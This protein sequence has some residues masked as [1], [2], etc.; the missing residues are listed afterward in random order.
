MASSFYDTRWSGAL[1]C[2]I[3]GQSGCGKTSFMKQFLKH[4]K[5]LVNPPFTRKIWCYSE[6]QVAYQSD[7]DDVEFIKGINPDIVSRENLGENQHVALVIDD[8]SDE[9]DEQFLASLFSKISHHR[10][11]SIFF[12]VHSLFLASMKRHRFISQ[13]THVLVIFKSPRDY[14]SVTTL[15]RQMFGSKSYKFAVQAFEDATK[16]KHGYLVV[17][18]K[19][20]TPSQLRLRTAIFPN[21]PNYVYLIP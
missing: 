13:N 15:F 6:W 12:L 11:V 16:S 9:I 19:A 10:M 4:H 18:S 2:Q 21:Q 20:D 8:L 5:Q 3:S 1:T 7:M 14:S 17:S